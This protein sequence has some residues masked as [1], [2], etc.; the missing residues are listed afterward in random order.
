VRLLWLA[1]AAV[2]AAAAPLPSGVRI[3][4]LMA[5]LLLGP[6]LALSPLIELRDR[7]SVLLVGVALSLAIDIGVATAMVLADRWMPVTAVVLLA[8]VCMSGVGLQLL[9]GA[10]WPPASPHPRRD[11]A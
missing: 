9:S 5:F 11:A 4:I 8:A 6:G 2:V 3:A 1:A 10:T 7:F